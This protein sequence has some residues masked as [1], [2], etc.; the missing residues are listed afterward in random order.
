MAATK[1]RAV[2]RRTVAQLDEIIRIFKPGTIIGGHRGLVEVRDLPQAG[3]DGRRGADPQGRAARRVHRAPA[4]I[5]LDEARAGRV[6]G[7]FMVWT[8]APEDTP[9]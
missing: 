4:N 6:I 1:L 3:P 5:P 2:T 8:F 9:S 7:V